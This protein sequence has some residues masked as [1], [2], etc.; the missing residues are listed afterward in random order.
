MTN[1]KYRVG[2]IGVGEIADWHARA[3]R[4]AGMEISAVSARQ[5]SGRLPDFAARHEIAR[6]F[7]D[8]KS[9]LD[10]AE[11]FDAL[12]VLTW[13]DGTPSVLQ[14]AMDLGVPILVEKPVAWNSARLKQLCSKPNGHVIVG[15]NRRFYRPVQEARAEVLNGPPLLAQLTLPTQLYP[16]DGHDPTA[17]YL[18]S[19]FESVTAHGL[20]LTRF[21][22]G[23]LTLLHSSRLMDSDG[24]LAGV[25]AV[26]TTERGDLLQ[27]TGNFA[28][29]SNFSL[30]LNRPGRRF[31]LLPFEAA[32]IYAGM[33]ILPPNAEYPIRRY[34]PKKS[35]QI[36]LDNIDLQEKPG[37]VGEAMALLAMVQGGQ[38][39][40]CTARLGDALAVTTLCEQ[41]TGII[42]G[43]SN[44]NLDR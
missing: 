4:T 40:E 38:P 11:L 37:L 17:H 22:M 30:V 29:T 23:N 19:F 9:M 42:L 44:P 18:Y 16:H 28:A 15:Y 6:T 20:D 32:T 39:P 24:N 10:H 8:W 1:R 41:I 12:A 13:P 14:A 5:G 21:V 27:V 7:P 25:A 33:E 35:T 3:L 36:N 31:D 34:I 43:D 2:M 26:L